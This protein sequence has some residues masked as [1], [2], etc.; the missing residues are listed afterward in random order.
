[1]NLV[2]TIFLLSALLLAA[3]CATTSSRLTDVSLKMTKEQVRRVLGPPESVSLA[4][5]ADD[6][7]TVEVLDWRL[8]QYSGAIDGISPYYNIY[9]FVFV[10]DSLVRWVK[11]QENARLTEQM[12]L[13]IVRGNG[14][15]PQNVININ[16]PR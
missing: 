8:Y 3:S 1:M 9:S 4:F 11:T 10:N 15:Y 6:G 7:S 2:R 12:A 14:L 13:E 16:N 5:S